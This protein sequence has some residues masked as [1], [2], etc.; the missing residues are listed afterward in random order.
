MGGHLPL[1]RIRA[2]NGSQAAAV[3]RVITAGIVAKGSSTAYPN[4]RSD[5]TIEPAAVDADLPRDLHAKPSDTKQRPNAPE[6]DRASCGR[7][8]GIP[9]DLHA[10]DRVG[11]EPPINGTRKDHVGRCR[12]LVL[13]ARFGS[14]CRV[15]WLRPA[16]PLTRCRTEQALREVVYEF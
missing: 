10:V 8:D 5:P 6:W 15:V 4:R 3:I 16:H 9:A 7:S 12:P 13:P 14:W 11:L 2:P 1:F